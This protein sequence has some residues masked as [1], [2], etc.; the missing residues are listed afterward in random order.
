[1]S[2]PDP[3]LVTNVTWLI[4]N[5]LVLIGSRHGS[6]R[7]A[8]S[9][10]WVTQLAMEPVLLGLSVQAEAITTRLIRGG[11]SYTVNL[12]DAADSRTLTRFAK[13]ARDEGATLTGHAVSEAPSGAPV[14]DEAVAWLDCTVRDTLELGSHVLFIGEVTAVFRRDAGAEVLSMKD[15]RMKYGGVVRGGMKRH[16]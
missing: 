3:G 14:F 16:G 1:M 9:A 6:E 4:P 13:P 11:G 5:A 12:W 2:E 15:T 8:M 10:S 7:N